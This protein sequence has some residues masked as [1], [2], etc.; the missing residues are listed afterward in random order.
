MTY[1]IPIQVVSDLNCRNYREYAAWVCG[2]TFARWGAL[3]TDT[4]EAVLFRERG[5]GLMA[6]VASAFNIPSSTFASRKNYRQRQSRDP[7]TQL[8]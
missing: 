8:F 5:Q 1:R 6:Q 4:S 7:V 3:R 2:K